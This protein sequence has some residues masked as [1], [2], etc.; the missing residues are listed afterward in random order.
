MQRAFCV[1]IAEKHFSEWDNASFVAKKLGLELTRV[2]LESDVL[3]DFFAIASHA[4]DPLAD[5]SAVCVWK[6]AQTTAR[7]FK[8]ALSG[9]GGD[10][11][12]GG[13]PSFRQIPRLVHT[14]RATGAACG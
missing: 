11:L 10:E 9:L 3:E 14:L 5:S 4:D 7:D 6:L 1:D 8:V 12:F 13:Y 2:P